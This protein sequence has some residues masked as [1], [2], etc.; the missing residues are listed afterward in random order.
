MDAN[1]IFATGGVSGITGLI[2]FVLYKLLRHTRIKSE[3]CGRKV[4]IETEVSPKN[5][6][7]VDE[8]QGFTNSE[9]GIRTGRGRAL[10]S[11]NL[12][13]VPQTST[14]KAQQEPSSSCPDT[15]TENPLHQSIP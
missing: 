4:L 9:T 2:L 12:S 11:T 3:C 5:Q 10:S 8:K 13:G 15:T 14:A 1:Q 6:A 7:I